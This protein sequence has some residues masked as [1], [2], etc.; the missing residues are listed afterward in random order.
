MDFD[1]N[2][3]AQMI[4]RTGVDGAARPEQQAE[5]RG[6]VLDA[7]DRARAAADRPTIVARSLSYG[8]WL[9]HSRVSRVAATILIV[10]MIAGVAVWFH[11]GGA[12][13]ALAD[14]IAP[15]LDAKSF[16]CKVV[17]DTEGQP[18]STSD[19]VWGLPNRWR[20][21]MPCGVVVGDLDRGKVLLLDVE[22]KRAQVMRIDN[23]PKL[24]L[25]ENPIALF[26]SQ[27]LNAR[28]DPDVRQESLGETE[29]DGRRVVGYR[30]TDKF[31][32]ITNLWGDP[33]TGI[34]VRIETVLMPP[35][36][37]KMTM[38]GFVF[39]V[40]LDESQFS[41]D[42][43]AGYAIQNVRVDASP[44]GE[45][46]LIE[47]FRY[48]AE[49]AGAFPDSLNLSEAI[50]AFAEKTA[51]KTAAKRTKKFR[52]LLERADTKK[53]EK[54]PELEPLD[55]QKLADETMKLTRGLMFY[56][57]LKP[58]ADAHYA[59]KGV[60]LG[61]TDTPIFWYR[62]KEGKKYRI[63]YADLSVHESDTPPSVPNGQR[64]PVNPGSKK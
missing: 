22:H 52:E 56:V 29:I 26:R 57:D 37:T 9:M 23:L 21:E 14:F 55:V 15:I 8:R 3:L 44:G 54:L 25:S 2:T 43:P 17:D 53:M 13:F 39:D 33:R 45:K 27:L 60:L 38:T 64:A 61:A 12:S 51:E 50:S 10:L 35:S 58:D 20:Q 7:F 31:G 40:D 36:K 47:T 19:L 5:L 34:P 49:L 32:Q 42:P 62:P 24:G 28:H 6:R 1:E 11:G 4:E 59:G 63:I 46:D 48:C 16:K 18:S 41:L 30:L